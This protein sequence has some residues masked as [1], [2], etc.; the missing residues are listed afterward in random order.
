MSDED[1][2][3]GDIEPDDTTTDGDDEI[4]W[5]KIEELEEQMKAIDAIEDDDERTQAAQR[6]AAEMGGETVG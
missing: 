3:I 6:W 1:V 5:S 2:E 4:D